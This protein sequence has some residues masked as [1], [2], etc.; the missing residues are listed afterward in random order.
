MGFRRSPHRVA[1]VALMRLHVEALFTHD[2]AGDL[3]AVNEPNG[4]PAPR[5]FLGRTEGGTVRRF[6]H[7]VGQELREQLIAVPEDGSFR[8]H[9]L[10]APVNA[11]RYEEVLA[12]VTAVQRTWAG[13]AYSFPERLPATNDAVLITEENTQLLEAHLHPWIPD[14]PLCQPMLALEVAGHAVAV[15]GSVRRTDMA[16]EAGVETVPS[17]RGRGYAAKVATAWARA[18]RDMARVPLYS[19]S[20]RNAAS[21]AVARKLGLIHFGSDMHIT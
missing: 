6:R 20:W 11:S 4:A 14:V 3:V 9:P 2:A 12:R 21:R 18:V 1:A 5:F 15:C 17:Y 7:D 13:P 19:T 16:H 10:D 8:D